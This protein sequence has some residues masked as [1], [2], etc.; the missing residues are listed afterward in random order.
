MEISLT[1]LGSSQTFPLPHLRTLAARRFCSFSE[2][3]FAAECW[4]CQPYHGRTEKRK[5]LKS[6]GFEYYT[7]LGLY[8]MT[9][10]HADFHFGLVLPAPSLFLSAQPKFWYFHFTPPSIFS[11]TIIWNLFFHHTFLGSV[12]LP[13]KYIF[14]VY[15]V[16]KTIS[17]HLS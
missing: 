1:S 2:T 4:W 5:D 15:W 9:S 16:A 3:I 14:C 12:F 7:R 11:Q 6:L 10:F 13:E 17:F 8:P